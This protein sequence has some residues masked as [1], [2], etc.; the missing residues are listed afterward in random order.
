MC[1]CVISSVTITEIRI[2]LIFRA[3]R[4]NIFRTGEGGGKKYPVK[5]ENENENNEKSENDCYYNNSV[6]NT[7]ISHEI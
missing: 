4:E 3:V 1:V 6:S 2:V 7:I 5:S